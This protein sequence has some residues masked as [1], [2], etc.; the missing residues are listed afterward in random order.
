MPR[1]EDRPAVLPHSSSFRMPAGGSPLRWRGDLGRR[2]GWRRQRLRRQLW[3]DGKRVAAVRLCSA[4]DR[5]ELE[6][7]HPDLPPNI[8]AV[9]GALRQRCR[10]AP[11]CL[12]WSTR[13]T[14][15]GAAGKR[16]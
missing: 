1:V 4:V 5:A 11:T 3:D 2:W 16:H 10:G 13:R 15:V 8:P 14:R 7:D 9:R 6:H 12:A